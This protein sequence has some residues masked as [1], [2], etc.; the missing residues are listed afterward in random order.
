[1]SRT[2]RQRCGNLWRFSIKNHV[3]PF[4]RY[5][6]NERPEFSLII[7]LQREGNNALW[8]T[9]KTTSGAQS[10]MQRLGRAAP[11]PRSF[12]PWKKSVLASTKWDHSPPS[13]F[14]L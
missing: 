9:D 7:G 5:P 8:V 6:Y 13:L 1:M 2:W 14:C 11:T 10:D 12:V 3:V 4:S